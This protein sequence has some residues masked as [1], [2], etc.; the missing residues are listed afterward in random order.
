MSEFVPTV[1][2][3]ALLEKAI[4]SLFYNFSGILERFGRDLFFVDGDALLAHVLEESAPVAA[5]FQLLPVIYRVEHALSRLV[6]LGAQFRVYFLGAYGR[7]GW[8]GTVVNR[9]NW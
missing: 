3:E 7:V 9:G 5:D 8:R 6:Q 2:T 4:N 1:T